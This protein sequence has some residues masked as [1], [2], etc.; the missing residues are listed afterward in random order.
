MSSFTAVRMMVDAA[1]Q[2]PEYGDSLSEC[3]DRPSTR[4]VT[5]VP[6]RTRYERITCPIRCDG[7]FNLDNLELTYLIK[8]TLVILGYNGVAQKP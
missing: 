4:M 3:L 5:H 7:H 2:R 6:F 1:A 8:V